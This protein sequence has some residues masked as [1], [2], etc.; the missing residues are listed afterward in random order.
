M[1][2]ETW[3]LI[4]LNLISQSI[5]S[6]AHFLR[7]PQQVSSLAGIHKIPSDC[8]SIPSFL[9]NIRPLCPPIS[10]V[11]VFFIYLKHHLYLSILICQLTLPHSLKLKAKLHLT[12]STTL[13]FLFISFIYMLNLPSILPLFS[14]PII[15]TPHRL[16]E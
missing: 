16:S 9:S 3:S 15:I 4:S 14:P 2:G 1:N 10:M 5:Y 6:D 11:V 13:Q 7:F 8:S 12:A